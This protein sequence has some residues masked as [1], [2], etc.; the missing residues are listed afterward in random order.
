MSK[1]QIN[2]LG[3]APYEGMKTMMQRLAAKRD[4]INLTVFVGDLNE[5]VEIAKQNFQS[6]YDVIISRGGTAEM[7]SEITRIPL[8]EINLSVYDILRAIKLAENYSDRYAIVGYH[9]ITSSAQLLCD[10]LQYKIDIFTLHNADEVE[11]ILKNLKEQGYHMV[12][13]DMITKTTAKH[14]GLNA[15]LITSGDESILSAFDQ[16]EKLYKTYFDIRE[17]H[18][19]LENILRG[20]DN[21]I[22][23]FDE[24]KNIT[25]SSIEFDSID[26]LFALLKKEVDVS[27]HETPRK[28]VKVIDETRFSIKSKRI[29]NRSKSYVAYYIQTTHMPMTKG[30]HGVKYSNKSEVEDFFFNSFYSVTSPTSDLK[31]HLDQMSHHQS[32]IMVIG[33][34]G[35]G[36]S[37]I[38]RLLYTQSHLANNPFI[39]FDCN[40]LSDKTWHFLL[41]HHDSPLCDADNTLF[42]KDLHMLTDI[43]RKQLLSNILDSK[44]YKRNRFIFSYAVDH[45]SHYTEAATSFINALSCMT[46]TLKPLKEHVDEI[47]K[48]SSLYI[49][50]LNLNL[51]KQIIG[52][53][54]DALKRL[55]SY[56]WPSN[57]TQFK[58]VLEEMAVLTTTPYISDKTVETVLNKEKNFANTY[59]NTLTPENDHII[60][61]KLNT[62]SPLSDINKEIVSLYVERANGNHSLAAKR[63]GIS[64]T[65]LWRYLK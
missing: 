64:R 22:V 24:D 21:S 12:L 31:H 55:Q 51:A 20:T 11:S 7:I 17:E 37:Q 36:K 15:I 28:F 39:T 18:K 25:F 8:I 60:S 52:F 47:A 50:N 4:N 32:P 13:C 49:S 29:D 40:L 3:V 19:F 26:Y 2:I 5:G 33:E 54:P 14:L 44:S 43:R 1:R 45:L 41:N 65:T 48:L 56:N 30:K 35:T 6:N 53:E 38:A 23:V 63:L 57:Y 16:A 59:V 58:R 27:L 42:F 62:E 10:L 46:I 34:V 9:G 61:Y